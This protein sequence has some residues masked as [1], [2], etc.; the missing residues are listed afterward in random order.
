VIFIAKSVHAPVDGRTTKVTLRTALR[1]AGPPLIR[2]FP[3]LSLF[4]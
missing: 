3:G 4:S 1:K 2:P